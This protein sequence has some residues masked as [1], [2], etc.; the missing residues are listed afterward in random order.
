MIKTISGSEYKKLEDIDIDREYTFE[1]YKNIFSNLEEDRLYKIICH[2][3]IVYTNLYDINYTSNIKLDNITIV[4]LPYLREDID[5]IKFKYPYNPIFGDEIS[6]KYKP[7]RDKDLKTEFNLTQNN[8]EDDLLFMKF[9]I[10]LDGCMLSY[11]S[12]NLKNDISLISDACSKNIKNFEYASNEIKDNKIFADKILNIGCFKYFSLNIRN[13]K[14]IVLKYLKK[15]IDIFKYVGDNLKTKE[16]IFELLE[17][18]NFKCRILEYANNECRND[19]ELFLKCIEVERNNNIKKEKRYR[20]EHGIKNWTETLSLNISCLG[21]DLLNDK[22]LVI[23]CL[24]IDGTQIYNFPDDFEIDNEY[25]KIALSY[26]YSKIDCDDD[27]KD[28]LSTFTD[29]DENDREIVIMAIKRHGDNF[30]YAPEKL[31]NDIEIV[32]LAIQNCYWNVDRNIDKKSFLRQNPYEYITEIKKRID[33]ILE[34]TTIK[35]HQVIDIILEKLELQ[36]I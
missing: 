1:E 16:F 15:N 18:E 28:F 29:F 23:E 13:D 17:L 33:T 26:N 20:T 36:I 19:K 35:K 2:N 11:A 9:C 6:Y 27:Y 24:K 7:K 5:K 34:N 21:N 32:K 31:R 8:L 3:T 10:S 4:F 30:L 22:E 25:F 14:D 12:N